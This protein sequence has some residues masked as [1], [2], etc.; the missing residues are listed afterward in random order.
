MAPDFSRLTRADIE[1]LLLVC[2]ALV[3]G[4]RPEV[5]RLEQIEIGSAE[6]DEQ[7]E[8]IRGLTRTSLAATEQ[9]C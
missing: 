3:A 1:L 5:Q 7:I 8:A 2:E 4:H 9:T 6:W